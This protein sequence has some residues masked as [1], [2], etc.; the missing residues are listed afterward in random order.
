MKLTFLIFLVFE[1]SQI[2]TLSFCERNAAKLTKMVHQLLT[3]MEANVNLFE[4][5]YKSMAAC[6][7]KDFNPGAHIRFTSPKIHCIADSGTFSYYVEVNSFL[8]VIKDFTPS[9]RKAIANLSLQPKSLCAAATTSGSMTAGTPS[10]TGTTPLGR[11]WRTGKGS[12][13]RSC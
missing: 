2:F 10:I 4:K 1:C 11:T 13:A 3:L 9:T 12:S 8:T 5:V 6:I 7:M